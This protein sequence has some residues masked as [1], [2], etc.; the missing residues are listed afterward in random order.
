MAQKTKQALDTSFKNKSGFTQL[1]DIVDSA[2]LL[3]D[4]D[5]DLPTSDPETAGSLFLTG[6]AG[7]NLGSI[8]GSGFAILCVS[9]G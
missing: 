1:Q 5:N 7:M 4:G 2:L 9:Q 3:Q 8:T 6:S